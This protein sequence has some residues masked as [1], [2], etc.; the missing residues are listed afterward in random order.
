VSGPSTSRTLRLARTGLLAASSFALA[1]LAHVAAGGR[2]ESP[3]LLLPLAAAITVLAHVG[4]SPAISRRSTLPLHIALQVLSHQ[5]LSGVSTDRG[6]SAPSDLVLALGAGPS[7]TGGNSHVALSFEAI[8]RL[9]TDALLGSGH[10][11]LLPHPGSG[12]GFALLSLGLQLAATALI[13][14]TLHGLDQAVCRIWCWL[15]P[16]FASVGSL[17][18]FPLH[19]RRSSTPVVSAQPTLQRLTRRRRRR[20]PPAPLHLTLAA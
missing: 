14:A 4:T 17:D 3:V 8:T 7:V 6:S 19:R 2:L 18:V 11:A 9:P 13:V 5:V 20:G 10:A 15:Q 16:L 1:A 12:S